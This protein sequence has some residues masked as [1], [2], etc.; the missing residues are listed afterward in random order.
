M[1]LRSR[2]LLPHPLNEVEQNAIGYGLRKFCKQVEDGYFEEEGWDFWVE[3]G[4]AIRINY[5]GRMRRLYIS[6]YSNEVEID[7]LEAAIIT[8]KFGWTPR[9]AFNVGAYEDE[10]VDHLLLGGLTLNLAE[11]FKG[12]IDYCGYLTPGRITDTQKQF[13][14][15]L[16]RLHGKVYVVNGAYQHHVSDTK[17]LHSWLQHP[18]FMMI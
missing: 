6:F 14:E 7:P 9:Y 3:N 11:Q 10:R 5:R 13:K 16:K 4:S 8:A 1:G 2:I 15:R 18:N 12:L 17:F